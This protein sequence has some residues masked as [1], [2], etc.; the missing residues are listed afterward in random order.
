MFSLA[1]NS[2]GLNGHRSSTPTSTDAVCHRSWTLAVVEKC[3][4]QHLII[5]LVSQQCS[6]PCSTCQFMWRPFASFFV[7]RSLSVWTRSADFDFSLDWVFQISLSIFLYDY[8]W[9]NG[10]RLLVC[11]HLVW[12]SLDFVCHPVL[13]M[14]CFTCSPIS[15]HFSSGLST[16]CRLFHLHCFLRFHLW[17]SFSSSW[18]TLFPN[19]CLFLF[20]GISYFRTSF[21]G[22]N[23]N[24]VSRR[25]VALRRCRQRGLANW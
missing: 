25:E 18:A 22:L 13:L 16:A 17:I 12:V 14:Y 8:L 5:Y 10:F 20:F 21:A 9:S 1:Y 6:T 3:W 24:P 15:P 4:G 2:S 19:L 11:N 23:I 7:I